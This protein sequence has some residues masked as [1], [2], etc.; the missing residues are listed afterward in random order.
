M[1]FWV[2]VY[3]PKWSVM[4]W[5]GWEGQRQYQWW[6]Q[7]ENDP[8]NFALWILWISQ[9]RG[10][11]GTNPRSDP[12]THSSSS[13][14]GMEVLANVH[15]TH[16]RPTVI[17]KLTAYN[18]STKTRQTVTLNKPKCDGNKHKKAQHGGYVSVCR[19]SGSTANWTPSRCMR[20]LSTPITAV[21]NHCW[22]CGAQLGD[23][24]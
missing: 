18:V 12:H 7:L 17:R 9:W 23:L 16:L 4:I 6:V 3:Q 2:F 11:P 5:V 14:D 20:W 21:N 22:F 8:H 15:Y 13:C 19:S 10:H 24:N 1:C